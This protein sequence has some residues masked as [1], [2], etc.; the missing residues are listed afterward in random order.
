[1]EFDYC[2][3]GGGIAGL[4]SALQIRERFP[5][6]SIVLCEMYENFG[7]RIE[8]FR[9]SSIQFEKG[10]GRIHSSHKLCENLVKRYKLTKIPIPV[11]STAQWR[12]A[13]WAEAP[14]ASASAP[15]EAAENEVSKNM[16]P[17]VATFIIH[18]LSKLSPTTLQ[19]KTL[20][21]I[22]TNLLEGD[23]VK[24]VISRFA[25]TSEITTLRADLALE[26]FRHELG[27]MEGHF[28]TLKEGI[29]SIITHMMD[30]LRGKLQ[31][32]KGYRL[33]SL[34]KKSTLTSLH[35]QTTETKAIHTLNAHKV[36]LA[37]PS[38]ALKGISPF[39][40]FPVLK[41]ITMTPLLRIYGVFP[42]PPWFRDI[43]RTIT[44]SPIR[45]VIPISS[46]K[47]IVMTSYTDNKDTEFWMKIYKK[48]GKDVVSRRIV[49]ESEKLFK[50]KIPEP[51]LF[52]LYYWK[53]GCSY[54][55]PGL[56]DVNEAS[57]RMMYPLPKT[58]PNIFVCGESYSV[59]QAWI[60]SALQHT[61]TMLRTYI[62]T[63]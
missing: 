45:N 2:I 43:P 31:I 30:E 9:D 58:Y 20:E 15:A 38:E 33:V 54:W 57:R 62:F 18:I 16:W 50:C 42:T 25:Y 46:E 19:T 29:D 13:P 60:E 51:H 26:S 39:K 21:E 36:I 17:I 55:L 56:Y 61:D 6:A 24:R 40:N 44:D 1:M 41:K 59:N 27:G 22:L 48:Y 7:G 4:Y 52:K 12:S 5:N 3:V 8:T 10:A 53:H 37:I 28:Y 23:V 35:F 32:Y 47:G 49:E 63:K 14:G 11:E 34:E